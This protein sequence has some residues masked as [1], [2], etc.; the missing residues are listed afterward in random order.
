MWVGAL[1]GGTAFCGIVGFFIGR[2]LE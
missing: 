1:A 2:H